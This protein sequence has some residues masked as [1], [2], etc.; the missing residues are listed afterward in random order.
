MKK[1]LYVVDERQ[2]GGVS[3]L[4]EDTLKRINLNKYD[5][6][7]LVL[8]NNGDCLNNLPSKVNVIYGSSF[9]NVVDL[10]IKEVLKSK[11]IIKIFKKI[12]LVFLMKTGF[13]KGKI[14]KERKKILRKKYDVEIGYKDGFC[15]LFTAYGDSLKKYHWL[16]ADYA[17]WDCTSKYHKLFENAF[18]KFDKIIAISKNVMKNF[19]KVYP[20]TSCFVIYNLI[21]SEKII[22]KAGESKI[23]FNDELNF[24][25]VGRIHELKGYDRLVKVFTR[26]N[27]EGK[28]NG[29]VLR[30]IGDG[31][32]YHL[33]EKLIKENKL[34]KKVVLL[35]K[36]KNPFGYVSASDCF[37]MCSKSESFGLVILESLILGVPVLSLDIAS[38][39]EIMDKKYGMIEE[40]S[41]EGLY[42]SL[43]KILDNRNI[44]KKYKENLKDYKYDCDKIIAQI[45]SLLDK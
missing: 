27:E 45:E 43:S 9:F 23:K 8:H 10:N 29:V 31:P 2:M 39:R 15:A 21:D 18:L 3:I 28:L 36:K 22:K 34:E 13:I 6:D 38:I 4:L 5:I 40:N 17:T 32:D 37:I 41:F 19:Q 35:G 42:S 7:V 1:I 25:S 26:L 24:V 14:K 44:L 16:H 12:Y 20:N 30:I 11:N 33:I